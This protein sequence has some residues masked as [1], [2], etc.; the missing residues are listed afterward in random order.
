MVVDPLHVTVAVT[1]FAERPTLGASNVHAP[2]RRSD[3]IIH[4]I[5]I[6]HD[7]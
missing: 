2:T 1:R 6:L 3:D 5:L 7:T 4:G